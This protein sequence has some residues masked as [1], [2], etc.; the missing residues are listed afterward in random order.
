MGAVE[1]LKNQTGLAKQPVTIHQLLDS[2]RPQVA[3]ALPKHLNAERMIRIALTCL[4]GNSKLMDCE[5]QTI[6]AAVML[7]SQLGL[8]PGVLGQAYLVPYKNRASGRYICNFIPGWQGL[9]DI[10]NR[11]GK[12]SVWTGAVYKGDEFDWCLGDKPHIIHRP[13]GDEEVL[14]H[15]YAVGRPK[16]SEWPILEV[17]PA[18][19]IWKHRDRFNKVGGDHYSFQH[20][21]MYAR[22]VP[23]LQVLK[24]LP[25]SIELNVA[26]QLEEAAEE[27]LQK[28]EIKDVKGVLE[29]T[30]V[31]EPEPE[32]EAKPPEA[33]MC[34]ECRA[35]GGHLPSCPHRKPASAEPTEAQDD[36]KAKGPGKHGPV[37]SE[38]QVK[39][40]VTIQGIAGM[41]DAV[42]KKF[43]KATYGIESRK[44]IPISG[45]EAVIEYIDPEGLRNTG[46]E[47]WGG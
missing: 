9:V 21:P 29:G 32:T 36:G 33:T 5:P 30:V 34:A 41:S 6:L 11:S 18:A 23:L 37:I 43:L 3:L 19:K 47:G 44:D 17:W 46:E 16:G 28:Y 8:E 10:V 24:Y 1:T 40:L 31:S 27:G 12:A 39:R 38:A 22:K 25:K 2:L 4:R 7:A 20:G 15:T 35:I 45:Y 13:C 26:V 42:L 14:T